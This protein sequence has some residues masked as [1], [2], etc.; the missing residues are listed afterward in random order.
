DLGLVVQV[1][2]AL[3]R[4]DLDQVV[5][6]REDQ[7][8]EVA[9]Q[10]ARDRE[11]VD[12]VVLDRED[13]VQEDLGLVVQVQEALVQ[14]DLDQVVRVPVDQDL[15]EVDQVVLDREDQVREVV[16]P[17][18]LGLVAARAREAGVDLAVVPGQAEA[19][20]DAA[21]ESLNKESN[22]MMGTPSI[23]T[24]APRS[25]CSPSA[26]TASPTKTRRNATI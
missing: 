21:M 9:D 2:E 24:T 22:A 18:D 8:R 19:T 6:D 25:A 23:T 13:Q 1:Q 3:V 15:V 17:G 4:A 20:G 14:E 10:V 12:Q 5:L 26:E 16:G 7:V 11:V